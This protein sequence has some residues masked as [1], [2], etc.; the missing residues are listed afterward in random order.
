MNDLAARLP[1]VLSVDLELR[2]EFEERVAEGSTLAYRVAFGVLRHRQDAEDVAQEALIRAYRRFHALRNRESFR[3]W[4]V[5]TAWRLALDRRR[6]DQR[7]L[8][9]DAAPVNYATVV[10]SVI[11][12]ALASERANQ[13]WQAID[14]LPEK[15]RLVVVL[16]AIQEADLAEVAKLLGVPEGTVKSRLFQAR[17][18]LR[19][20]LQWTRTTVRNS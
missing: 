14:R 20:H 1:S 13:L 10:P 16:A 3:A 11:D 12:E 6:G 17:R 8:R 19:E 9:R 15:L 2:R 4:L 5:R 7:R 18:Q